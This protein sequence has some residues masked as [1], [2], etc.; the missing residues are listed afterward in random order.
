MVYWFTPLAIRIADRYEFYDRPVGYKAHAQPT[1]YLGGAAV[2]AGFLLAVLLLAGHTERTLPLV[3]GV[4][5]L[6]ALGTLDDRRTVSP[7]L[8]VA[9]EI[10]LAALLWK[11]GLG[12]DLGAGP[13]LDLAVTA[14][15]VVAV[16]N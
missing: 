7:R 16:V 2:I 3:F 1:P 4:A 12:W 10:A 11:A 6:W 13:A 5:T 15:W 14:F 9:V 8:R